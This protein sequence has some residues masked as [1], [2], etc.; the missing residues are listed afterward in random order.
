MRYQRLELLASVQLFHPSQQ[1][2]RL[3]RN[4]LWVSKLV[5]WFPGMHHDQHARP[6]TATGL[7]RITGRD[8]A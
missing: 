7:A 1:E 8:S 3:D 4:S 2:G 5:P 6:V